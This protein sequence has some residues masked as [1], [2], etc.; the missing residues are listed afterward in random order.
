MLSVVDPSGYA[1]PMHLANA[2]RSAVGAYPVGTVK[3]AR[4]G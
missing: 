4:P 1:E 3:V 2:G